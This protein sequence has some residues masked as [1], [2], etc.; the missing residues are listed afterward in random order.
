VRTDSAEIVLHARGQMDGHMRQ[1]IISYHD[2]I[3]GIGYNIPSLFPVLCCLAG[4]LSFRLGVDRRSSRRPIESVILT[5]RL[6]YLLLVHHWH[7]TIV[8]ML[9]C[10]LRQTEW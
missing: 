8:A 9:Q 2:G 7:D 10:N 1:L 6:L 3:V 5:R 4:L